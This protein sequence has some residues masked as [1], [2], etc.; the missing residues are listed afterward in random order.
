M[1]DDVS[2][3]G[4]K[5]KAPIILLYQNSIKFILRAV[6]KSLEIFLMPYL[7][8]LIFPQKPTYSDWIRQNSLLFWKTPQPNFSYVRTLY[9]YN[10]NH[11]QAQARHIE[12]GD[13]A[14]DSRI[15]TCFSSIQ[16]YK[17]Y[18]FSS[19]DFQVRQ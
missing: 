14:F 5:K 7:R 13:L 4:E 17:L 9:N 12:K 2:G 18:I 11:H 15:K 10:N 8:K 19:F 1:G 6:A 3:E 16:L